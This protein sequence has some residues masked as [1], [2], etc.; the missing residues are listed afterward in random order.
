MN[1]LIVEDDYIDPD[2][3][4]LLGLI[5]AR[6]K[7]I[8]SPSLYKIII[9]FPTGNLSIEAEDLEGTVQKF[10][11]STSIQLGMAQIRER[12]VELMDCDVKVNSSENN[13]AMV[14]TL[15]RRTMGWRNIM[16]HLEQA[17]DFRHMSVPKILFHPAV[18][19]DVRLEFVRGFADVAANI[20]RSNNHFG[21]FNRVRLDVLNNKNSWSLPIQLCSL[22]QQHLDIPV[23][24]IIW[25]HPNLGREFREHMINVFVEPFQRIGSIFDHKKQVL[26]I[27]TEQDRERP[28]RPNLYLPCPGRRKSRTAKEPHPEE[29]SDKLPE[30]V[31]KHYDA[32]WQICKAAGCIVEPEPGPL[33]SSVEVEV[34]ES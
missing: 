29:N 19:S 27:L 34:D 22:M 3:A 2:V 9:D 28:P 26:D 10:N 21:E 1:G 23:Q 17:T 32:Y 14:L 7:I 13:Y 11:I 6:G 20:R 31:R 4:Y 16:M 15:T 30:N 25:G 8:Q 24:S 5:V 12:L 18:T 33:F